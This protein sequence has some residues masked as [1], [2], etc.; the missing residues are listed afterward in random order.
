MIEP[1]H[2][3]ARVAVVGA[4]HVGSTF[5]YALLLSGLADE[6]FV[7]A[8]DAAVILRSTIGLLGLQLV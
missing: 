1:S 2:R 7:Q 3:A 4:G 6:I 8:R 5:A